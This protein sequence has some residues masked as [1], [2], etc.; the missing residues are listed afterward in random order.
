M[1]I[2]KGSKVKFDDEKGPYRVRAIGSRY[3]VCTKPYN[4]KR[5]VMYTVIDFQK[6]IRGTENLCFCLGAE[7][8][9]DCERMLKR[10][11]SGETEVSH[12][13]NVDYYITHINGEPLNQ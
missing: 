8:D 4:F 12:R 1:N 6:E 9:E 10:L 13:N 3:A 2:E 5:T 7:T 11:E